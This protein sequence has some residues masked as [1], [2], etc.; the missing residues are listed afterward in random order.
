LENL[1]EFTRVLQEA[2]PKVEQVL[3]YLKQ[4]TTFL[5]S[6]ALEFASCLD[7]WIP[8]LKLLVLLMQFLVACAFIE[9]KD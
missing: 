8:L 4:L 1:R 2:D 6:T 3:A 5:S 9:N 7:S